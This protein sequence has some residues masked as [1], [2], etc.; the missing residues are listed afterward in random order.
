MPYIFNK[1]NDN[2][3]NDCYS[4]AQQKPMSLCLYSYYKYI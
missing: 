2:N 1:K 3:F 4:N